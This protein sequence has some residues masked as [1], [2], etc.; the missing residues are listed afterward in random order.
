MNN[1]DYRITI[2]PSVLYHCTTPKKAKNYRATGHIIAPVRGFTTIEA[3]LAW[4]VK[5]GRTVVYQIPVGLNACH[6]LPDHHNKFG[7]AWYIE[8]NVIHFKCVFSADK[9]A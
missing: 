1:I 9:D 7:T 2:S 3:A 6:K 8:N 5:T 4:C